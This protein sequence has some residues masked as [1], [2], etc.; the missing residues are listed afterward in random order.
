MKKILFFTLI[1]IVLLTA[2]STPKDDPISMMPDTGASVQTAT[3]ASQSKP[4]EIIPT[5]TA[6]PVQATAMPAV[7]LAATQASSETAAEVAENGLNLRVGPGLNHRILGVLHAGEKVQVEGRSVTG[8]WIAVKLTDGREGWVYATYLKTQVNLAAL[9]V[10]EAYGGPETSSQPT[11]VPSK[12]YTM[13]MN[14]ENGQAE[15]R[16]GNFPAES[17][18]T[19]QLSARGEDRSMTVA[20]VMVGADRSAAVSFDMPREWPDGTSISQHDLVL[21][22]SNSDGSLHRSINISYDSGE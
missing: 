11:A 8:E 3:R 9:P 18:I 20:T 16:L 22:A 14:I 6:E 21:T 2:C 7:T 4:T 10:R 12:R 17:E 19:L 13:S 1:V 5:A 15:V